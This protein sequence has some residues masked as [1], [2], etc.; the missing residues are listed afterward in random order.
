MNVAAK[1]G[2]KVETISTL[3]PT[4]LYELASSTAD[5]QAEVERRIAAGE[6]IG[7]AAKWPYLAAFRASPW[8]VHRQP[9]ARRSTRPSGRRE[10]RLLPRGGAAGAGSRQNASTAAPRGPSAGC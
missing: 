6:I 4:A 8:P 3:G 1:F 9:S 2:G 7:A 10:R 5:V